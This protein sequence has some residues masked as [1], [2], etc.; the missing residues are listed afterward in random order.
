[1]GILFVDESKSRGYTMVAAAVDPRDLTALRREL[2]ALVLPGQRR[3]HFTKES[4]SRKRTVVSRL[5]ELGV[6]AYLV[7][8]SDP[9]EASA[10][11]DCLSQLVA[12]A[13][14]DGHTRIVLERDESIERSDRRVLYSEVERRGL[15]GSVTYDHEAAHQEP[16]LWIADAIAWSHTKGGDWRRRIEPL[17]V[18]VPPKSAKLGTPT[19]RKATE[20]TSRR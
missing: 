4:D 12:A 8:S 3:V 18:G 7:R 1:M 20:L 14:R 15:H 16:L 5:T 13:V 19:V 10:R 11:A 2:R 17:L 9:G 6:R